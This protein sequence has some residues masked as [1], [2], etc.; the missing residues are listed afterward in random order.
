MEP[1]NNLY[2]EHTGLI[3]SRVKH[4]SDK[5]SV[6][7]EDVESEANEI[8]C[9]ACLSYD[10]KRGSSFST[11]LY[12]NLGALNYY[13]KTLYREWSQIEDIESLYLPVNMPDPIALHESIETLTSP[14]Q[15]IIQALI[16]TGQ[17]LTITYIRQV[18]KIGYEKAAILFHE[19]K[20][21][22]FDF[23]EVDCYI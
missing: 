8:F 7:F 3:K 20:V 13:S 15:D 5:Y 21:W 2:K 9:K 11:H 19:I 18:L 14:A 23:K 6:P 17:K 22:W 12:S 16:A 10:V 4:Y 1:T